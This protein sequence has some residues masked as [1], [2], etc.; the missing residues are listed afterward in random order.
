MGE[1]WGSGHDNSDERRHHLTPPLPKTS[2][3]RT[4]SVTEAVDTATV[5]ISNMDPPL[6]QPQTPDFEVLR[7]LHLAFVLASDAERILD[8]SMHP[9]GKHS[10]AWKT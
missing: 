8:G 9:N 5:N 1:V 6:L 3:N 2:A 7:P 10:L 4:Y